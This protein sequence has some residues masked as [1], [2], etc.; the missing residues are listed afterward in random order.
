MRFKTVCVLLAIVSAGLLTGRGAAAQ[1]I[2]L[3]GNWHFVVDPAGKLQPADLPSLTSV[4]LAVPGSWQ[5]QL[6][7]KRDY[8]GVAWYFRTVSI[9]KIPAERL[10]LLRFG[11]VDYRAEVYVNGQKVGTHEGGYLPFTVDATA[12]LRAGANQL[13]VRVTDPGAPPHNVVDGIDYAQIPH[14]KQNWYVETGGLWQSVEL[15]FRPRTHLGSLHV[16]AD[17]QGNFRIETVIVNPPDS[18]AKPL[19][20]TE[21]I[22]APGGMMMWQGGHILHAQ[23]G[24][25]TF[26]GKLPQPELWN[27][28]HPV[29]YSLSARLTNGDEL[30]TRFGFRTFATRDGK[31]YLNGR[32]IY[33]RGALDQAFYPATGYTPPS[34][35][36]LRTEMRRAKELGFNLLRCHIKV[37]DPRYLE[38]A[39]ETGM[40]VWYEIPSWSKLTDASEA[41]ALDTLRGMAAR[42][43][44]HPSIV[45]VTLVNESWGIDLH[46]APDRAWLKSAYAQAKKIVPGWLVDD[47][48]ACC[49]N[50]HVQTDLA[51][52]HQYDSIPGHAEDFDRLVG[53]FATRPRW[54]FS[55]YGD[56]EPKGDEPLVLSE[57]GNWGLPKLHQPEPW[58]FARGF[59]NNPM[60]VPEGVEKRFKEYGYSSLFPNFDALA[61]ATQEHQFRSLRYEIGSLRRQSAI[62]GYVITELT[63]VDWE[64]NGVLDMWR[65]PKVFDSRLAQLQQDNVLVVRAGTRN[66]TAGAKAHAQVYFSRFGSAP[67]A[68]ATVN[69]KVEGTT[70]AGSFPL[71]DVP[72]DSAAKVGDVSFAAPGV[73]APEER[74]LQ[75]EIAAG[76][77]TLAAN[78][79]RFFFY[80]SETPLLPPPVSFHDPRGR[81]RRLVNEMRARNYQAPVGHEAFP[82][83]ISSVW[84]AT[85]QQKLAQGG[86]VILLTNTAAK[87]APGIEIVPR[88]EDHLDGS[89]I[90]NFLWVRPGHAPFQKLGFAPL[91]GFETQQVTPQA[92]V[93]GIPAQNFSDVLAGMFYGWVQSNVGVLVQARCGPGKLFISTF[94]LSTSYGTDPY[95]TAFLDTLV[96]YAVS[97]VQPHFQIP[98]EADK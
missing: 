65:Q 11:A 62:Q 64:S 12:A 54:L 78:S 71:P 37:P 75:V 8:A 55:P 88:S 46:D 10:A 59:E 41:R 51:D 15:E 58:W 70:L 22:K 35:D 23:E 17:H 61:E 21:E 19:I 7:D 24:S 20:L 36:Y 86:I 72:A 29:L 42:D 33:L 32:L 14:G 40:L 43:W 60:T 50:F 44:N 92:V 34:L 77:K 9:E 53:D 25:Y 38:A 66:Y 45:I 27:L 83:L 6:A 85:V 74:T 90:S 1:T 2:S 5:A 56:A 69:W 18:T 3:D 97:G 76:G 48:S 47:N 87:L 81:L 26:T 80:P 67:P 94:S 82:V 89:W 95:A 16:T 31:F 84:D 52:Y 68:S 28:S 49:Q 96:N 93:Q 4:P 73:R 79:L 57:F 13:V 39:D 98:L 91:A 63:D 30:A